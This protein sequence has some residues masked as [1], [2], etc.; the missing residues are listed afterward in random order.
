M[1]PEPCRRGRMTIVA[2]VEDLRLLR[3]RGLVRIRHT[4]LAALRLA[5]E[6]CPAVTP[7]DVGPRAIEAL[8][9][10]AVENLGGG[11]LAAAAGY[12]FG[13]TPGWRDRPAQDRRRRAAQQYGVS[14]ER[15]RKHHERVVIEQVAE[16]VLELWNQRPVR[17]AA[18][19]PERVVGSPAWRPLDAATSGKTHPDHRDGSVPRHTRAEMAAELRLERRAGNATLPVV[20]HIEPVDLIRDVDVVV[21]PLNVYLEVPPAYK[22]SVA[23]SLR[24]AAARR[25]ADGAVEEDPVHDELQ[26]WLRVHGRAGVPVTAGT[27]APTSSG[28][29]TDQGIRRIY[30]AAVAAPHPGTNDYDVDPASIARAVQ[31][32]FAIARTERNLFDPPLRSLGFPLLGAGRGG[33]APETSFAWLWAAIQREASAGDDDWTVHF[34]TRRRAT[35]NVVVAGIDTSQRL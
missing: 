7:D 23:A 16:E 29:L 17:K 22:V 18:G 8:L 4:E 9:R 6:R 25:G 14:I 10:A 34:I 19:D 2:I 15:F 21:A 33:L 1:A 28:Q 3:E 30:H 13:L 24:R 31:R 11:E 32:V 5:A 27:V 12:T 20:V 26:H 35:A